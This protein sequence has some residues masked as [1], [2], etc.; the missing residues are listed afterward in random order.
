MKTLVELL[1]RQG[2]IIDEQD[3]ILKTADDDD[4]RDLTDEEETRFSELQAELKAL[5]AEAG[6][7]KKKEAR[8]AEV[9]RRKAEIKKPARQPPRMAATFTPDNPNEFKNLGEFFFSV[10]FKQNDSRLLY[11]EREQSMGVGAQGGFMVPD[12]F[13]AELLQVDPAAT[14]IIAAAKRLP[15]GAAPDAGSSTQKRPRRSPMRG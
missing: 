2:E 4:K 14:P 6:E 7:L 5:D 13:R 3:L 12:E 1:E 15:P 11:G 9:D 8:Q 10:R